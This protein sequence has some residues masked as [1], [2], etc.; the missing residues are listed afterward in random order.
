M[1]DAPRL[2]HRDSAHGYTSN[3][4]HALRGEP[5]AVPEGDQDRLT[6][7]AAANERRARVEEWQRRRE[8]IQREINWL[9]SQRL[10]RNVRSQL[11]ALQRQLDRLDRLVDRG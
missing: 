5:E 11:R 10:R 8:T 1:P 3:P 4:S 6:L 2:L 9:Y 7:A